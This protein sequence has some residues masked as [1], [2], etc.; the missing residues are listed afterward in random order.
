MVYWQIKEHDNK[1]LFRYLLFRYV[2]K[3]PFLFVVRKVIEMILMKL[4]T[5][6]GTKPHADIKQ[7]GPVITL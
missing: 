3:P 7:L 6:I 5:F 2:S 4:F 1:L